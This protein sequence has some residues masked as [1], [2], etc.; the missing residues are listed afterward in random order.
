MPEAYSYEQ[1]KQEVINLMAEF[2]ED[3]EKITDILA[4]VDKALFEIAQEK[5]KR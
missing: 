5:A 2:D 4:M 1:L 3:E